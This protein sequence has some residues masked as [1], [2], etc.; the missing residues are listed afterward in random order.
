MPR[1]RRYSRSH[2]PNSVLLYQYVQH[3]TML[4]LADRTGLHSVLLPEEMYSMFGTVVGKSHMV[5]LYQYVQ[6]FAFAC[7]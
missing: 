6:L 5:L 7:A 4:A 1:Y 3:F 2:T